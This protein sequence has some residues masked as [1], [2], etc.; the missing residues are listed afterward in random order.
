MKANIRGNGT[1]DR[2]LDNE[3]QCANGEFH[4]L[5]KIWISR[6]IKTPTK[7]RIY[8]A[9]VVTILL[10]GAEVWNTTKKQLKCL[11]FSI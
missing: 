5:W 11:R 10:N 9:A 8:K 3:I 2:D 6:T 4:Q 7:I 1:I